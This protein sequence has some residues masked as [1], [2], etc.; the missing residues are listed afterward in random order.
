MNTGIGDA[1]DLAWKPIALLAGRAPDDLLDSYVSPSNFCQKLGTVGA[2]ASS[3]G[4]VGESSVMSAGEDRYRAAAAECLEAARKTADLD[5]RAT[6]LL[7]AQRWL[8]LADGSIFGRRRLDVALD[9]FNKRQ[10]LD[11][12]KH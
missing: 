10:M 6:L 12:P 4:G 2:A 5:A 9:H 11:L 3:L 8:E 7:M 1:I